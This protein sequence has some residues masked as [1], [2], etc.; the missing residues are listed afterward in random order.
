MRRNRSRRTRISFFSFQDI[1]TSV[2]GVLLLLTLLLAFDL[3]CRSTLLRAMQPQTLAKDLSESLRGLEEELQQ[4]DM[5]LAD[6]GALA[7]ELAKTDESEILRQMASLDLEIKHLESEIRQLVRLRDELSE[8]R[9]ELRIEQRGRSRDRDRLADIREEQR[10]VEKETDELRATNRRFFRV[11]PVGG[12]TPWLVEISGS[13]IRVAKVGAAQ[14]SQRFERQF[15]SSAESAFLRWTDAMNADTDYFVLAVR[16]SGIRVFD[17]VLRGL[18][19]KSFD[20]GL[21]ILG[22]DGV[23]F[24]ESPETG[25]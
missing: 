24:D 22:E 4:L 11:P 21:E 23:L 6:R 2:T 3:V 19:S 16:S 18:R 13:G 12:K 15:L 10:R 5:L 8:K 25:S 20:V 17:A 1:I 9:S 7:A 14:P